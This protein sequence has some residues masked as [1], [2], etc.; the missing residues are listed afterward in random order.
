MFKKEVSL[1]FLL[2]L[3][4][5]TSCEESSFVGL[6]I[7]PPSDRF[8][9]RSV[10]DT[11]VGTSVVTRDS[12]RSIN[13]TRSLLGEM[14]DPLF[15]RSAASFLTQVGISA[16]VDF[17][18][19]PVADSLVL[20]LQITG[21][22]GDKLDPQEISI[23]ELSEL[24]VFDS[25]YYS[26]LDPLNMIYDQDL[27]GSD[28]YSHT[29]GDSIIALHITSKDFQDKLIFAP[30]SAVVSIGAFITYMKGLYVTAACEGETGALFTINLNHSNSRMSLFYRNT[31]YPDSSFRYDYIINESA[32][33]INLFDYDHSTAVFFDVIDQTGTDDTVFYVQ[34]GAGI[35]G[36]LDLD[37]LIN[38]R[39]SMPVSINSVRLILPVEENDQNADRF[40]PPARLSLFERGDDGLLYGIFDLALGD[41]YFGGTYNSQLKQYNLNITNFVQSLVK[42]KSDRSTIYVGVRDAGTIPNRVVFRNRNHSM[43]GAR[44]DI[45]YTRH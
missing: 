9:V 37:H 13:H 43:G 16:L 6:E 8:D 3:L 39:D 4:L 22:Y 28:V 44:L 30:D 45:T 19:D 1:L 14:N 11:E 18:T 38:W 33:R 15:G 2:S 31:D 40:P 10:T 29:Q 41:A 35:M 27:L 36:R 5:I 7:Q 25:V 24:I 34:G 42:G 12:V 32:N 20:Y 21:S 23:Y 17:G 26:N